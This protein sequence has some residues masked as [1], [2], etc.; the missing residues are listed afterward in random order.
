MI[1]RIWRLVRHWRSAKSAFSTLSHLYG[2]NAGYMEALGGLDEAETKALIGWLPDEGVLVEFGTLF[3]LTA[4]RIANAK[5]R[6]K[7]VA[8]DNFSWNP[9]G[10]PPKAHEEFARKILADEISRGQVEIR[11]MGSEEFRAGC[12]FVPEA[13]FLD[14]DHTYG[15][16]K[17]EIEWA[18]RLGVG[19]I[20]GHD[21]G[22]PNPS[23]G[24]TRAV[25]EAFAHVDRCGM[26][27]HA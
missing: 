2:E 21:Y 5:P 22:N 20:C 8:L 27:W 19:C 6:L 24:V 26:C 15:A 3:G 12:D 10:L 25:D 11:A 17:A 7:I 4:K 1:K 18:K 16:V 13:V 14:A 23:F 9:F